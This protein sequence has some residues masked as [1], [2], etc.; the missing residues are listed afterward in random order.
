VPVLPFRFG[1]V[2]TDAQAVVEELLART[3]RSSP[4]RWRN[5]TGAPS[6]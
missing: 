4:L 1:A 3:T 6:T 5:S 2:M